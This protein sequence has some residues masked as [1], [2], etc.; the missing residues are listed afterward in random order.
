V[1]YA[2]ELRRGR[3]RAGLTQERAAKRLGLSQGYL[4]LLENGKRAAQPVDFNVDL[5]SDAGR[6]LSSYPAKNGSKE[7]NA[8]GTTYGFVT[9]INLEGVNPGAY[10]LHVEARN[11]ATK[12]TVTRDI[13]IR[14]R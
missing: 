4:S 6:V 7:S 1:R 2:E 5:R 10:V 12:S 13:P 3:E 9:P 14:V 11:T 8:S